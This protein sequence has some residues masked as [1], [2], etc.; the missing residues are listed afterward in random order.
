MVIV[1]TP[2]L[3]TERNAWLK[4]PSLVAQGDN[5]EHHKVGTAHHEN[6]LAG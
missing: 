4:A 6:I 5:G 2:L 3:T 1:G